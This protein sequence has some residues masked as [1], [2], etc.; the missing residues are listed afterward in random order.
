MDCSL[1][2]NEENIPLIKPD[3]LQNTSLGFPDQ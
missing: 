3:R 2:Q 1:V